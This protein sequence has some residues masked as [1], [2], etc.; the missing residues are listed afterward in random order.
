MVPEG[1]FRGRVDGGLVCTALKVSH[2]DPGR[3]ARLIELTVQ[4]RHHPS[5]H[6]HL[7]VAATC[8]QRHPGLVGLAGGND[9]GYGCA[10][11]IVDAQIVIAGARLAEIQ[12]ERGQPATA[13]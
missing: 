9:D 13:M 11:P 10:P 4:R 12:Q 1:L 8:D 7:P 3:P 5:E 6:S 2:D